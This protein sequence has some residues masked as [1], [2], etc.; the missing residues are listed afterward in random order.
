[1]TKS[2]Y[3]IGGAGTGK[4]TFMDQIL[5]GIGARMGPLHDLHSLRNAKALVTLRGHAVLHERGMEGLYLGCMRDEFPGSDGLDR[6]SSPVG[7]AWLQAGDLPSFI[8]SEGATL[9]TRRFLT[10]LHEHTDLLLVYLKADD[11]VKE[12]RFAER[13]SNQKPEFVLATAT[14]S[15][16]LWND[17]GKLGVNGLSCDTEYPHAW[18]NVKSGVIEF[19]SS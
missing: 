14:R 1:M 4:S 10:A 16:N 2:V 8:I 17:M 15:E 18:E 9:A 12:L 13:G 3:I 6:A 19:L 5:R 7:E 11:F